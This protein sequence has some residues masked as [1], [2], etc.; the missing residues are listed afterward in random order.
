[1]TLYDPSG[2]PVVRH[3][4]TP[5]APGGPFTLT[6]ADPDLTLA[7]VL[8]DNAVVQR[9]LAVGVVE[10]IC[11]QFGAGANPAA[12]RKRGLVPKFLMG[13]QTYVLK[14]DG[15]RTS[16]SSPIDDETDDAQG[17]LLYRGQGLW[18][19]LGPGAANFLLKTLG[20]GANP[21][22]AISPG[23][24]PLRARV[25]VGGVATA[26]NVFDVLTGTSYLDL[27]LVGS[28]GGGGQANASTA[29]NI[30]FGNAGGGGGACRAIIAA[31]ASGYAY[32]LGAYGGNA[33][34]GAAST[35]TIP[36]GTDMTANGGGAGST[37]GNSNT[38]VVQG[39]TNGASAGAASTGN[40]WT[41]G[42]KA[43][44]KSFR[45]SGT[46]AVCGPGGASPG[47][48][49]GG[50]GR[51]TTGVGEIGHGYGGGGSGGLAING[52][53]AQAG[54]HGAP[55]ALIVVEYARAS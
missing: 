53:G 55:A 4:S 19:A 23:A 37:A 40:I 3:D 34:A 9:A 8:T 2:R 38:V 54:G 36:G 41:R 26:A 43:C 5:A 24:I 47:F 33:Q 49:V 12:Q 25:F 32:S 13:E 45:L 20:A 18:Y 29:G 10:L 39:N 27:I 17:S 7:K 31:P 48:G 51:T 6:L 42:G 1:M 52:A 46:V 21:L 11:R 16:F 30:S 28:G 15:A 44:Q 22:W 35:L 14:G 50:N